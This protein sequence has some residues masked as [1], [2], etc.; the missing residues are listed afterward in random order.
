MTYLKK[1][2]TFFLG[3]FLL[4]VFILTF[5]G[6]YI[7]A[8]FG[9]FELAVIVLPL[10]LLALIRLRVYPSLKTEMLKYIVNAGTFYTGVALVIFGLVTLFFGSPWGLLPGGLYLAYEAIPLLAYYWTARGQYDR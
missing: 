9:A 3:L 2:F 10:V 6:N 5:G 7:A 4:S 1:N 8:H